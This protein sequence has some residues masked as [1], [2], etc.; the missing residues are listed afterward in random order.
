M[1]KFVKWA[2]EHTGI[3]PFLPLPSKATKD[4]NI[5]MKSFFYIKW[6]LL[7]SILA[8][9]R[10][11]FVP[12]V[13][14][15]LLALDTGLRFVPMGFVRRPLQRL[16]ESV[17]ARLLLFLQ[18]FFWIDAQYVPSKRRN[19]TPSGLVGGSIGSGHLIIAN[20]VSYVD[21]LYLA[22]RYAP[23][24][25]LIDSSGSKVV[26]VNLHEALKALVSNEIP[27]SGGVN[28]SELLKKSESGNLGPVVVFPEGITTNG[29]VLIGCQPIID[30]A[31]DKS[32]VH[33]LSFSYDF[34][35]F[36]PSF[37]AGNFLTHVWFLCGQ[38]SNKLTVKHIIDA[39][40]P[41]P[42]AGADSA[43]VQ[44]WAEQ[45]YSMLASATSIQRGKVNRTVKIDFLKYFYEHKK[46]YKTK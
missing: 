19:P 18:G 35:E 30:S 44:T 8:A 38:I 3:H 43:A 11:P 31:I 28:L 26:P 24:F 14:V 33:V 1:E 2:D 37:P 45:L 36:S 13:W 21:L 5:V 7:G 29:R 39:D 34:N 32:R 22:F 25:T 4:A 23:Q 46:Q 15:L 20:N 6:F 9:V 12:L 17:V 40:L 27:T 10:L 41:A 16:I 42:E